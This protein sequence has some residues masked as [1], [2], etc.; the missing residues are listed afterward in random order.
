MADATGGVYQSRTT[1]DTWQP[2]SDV[3]GWSHLLFEHGEDSM[4]GLWRADP[5][6]E[7]RMTEVPIP[8]RETI[9]VLEGSVRVAVDGGESRDLVVGDMISIPAGSVVGW[10]P[11]PDCVV[12]WIYS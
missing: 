8:A 9:L 6:A 5:D 2:D 11:A 3:G 10:D 1:T 7:R 12:F 4:A